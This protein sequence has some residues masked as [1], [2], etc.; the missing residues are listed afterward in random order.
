MKRCPACGDEYRKGR[1][2]FLLLPTGELERKKVCQECAG[3]VAIRIVPVNGARCG[4]AHRCVHGE[5][6][7]EAQFCPDHR[8]R[9]AYLEEIAKRLKAWIIVTTPMRPTSEG[10]DKYLEGR[11]AGLESALELVDEVSKGRTP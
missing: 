3:T 5:C 2:V 4:G 1:I 11:K 8:E 10:V 7:R 9:P 6:L